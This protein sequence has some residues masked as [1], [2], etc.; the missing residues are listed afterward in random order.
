MLG[1]DWQ[2][3]EWV[4]YLVL[5]QLLVA[6]RLPARMMPYPGSQSVTNNIRH[7]FNV[8][9]DVYVFKLVLVAIIHI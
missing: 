7:I 9:A 4:H 1:G 3:D 2:D 5:P 8:Q 6:N